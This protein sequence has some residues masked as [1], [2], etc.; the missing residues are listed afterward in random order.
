MMRVAVVGGGQIARKVYLPTLAGMDDVELAVLVEPDGQRREAIACKYRFAA[1]V[2]SVDELPEGQV[3]AAFV[4]TPHARRR[5]PLT[6]LFQRGIDVFSEKP[7]AADLAEAEEFAELAESS[8]RIFMVGF[9]R[10]FM[11]AY[12]KAKEFIG[13]RPV[14]VCRGWKHAARLWAHSLHVLDMLR[15]FCG[16]PVRIQAEGNLDDA[17]KETAVGAV[18]RFDSG[19]M[20]LFET[21]GH[22]GRRQEELVAH[23]P[24]Y[25][26]EVLAP[27]EV[28]CAEEDTGVTEVFRPHTNEWYTESNRLYGFVDEIRHFLDAVRTRTTPINTAA[29]ALKSHRLAHDLLAVVR[30]GQS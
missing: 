4:L 26:V 14:W 13:E 18:I 24:V 7:M 16:E 1:A 15:F 2:A 9:N 29:D 20:G 12:L 11:P 3:D 30:A 6:G 22:Y 27:Y 28:V 21:A 25:T 8:G 5:S 10:R 17:A 23:G 19:A